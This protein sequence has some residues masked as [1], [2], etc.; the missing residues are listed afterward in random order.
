MF[1]KCGVK[2]WLALIPCVRDVKLGQVAGRENEGRV[3]AVSKALTIAAYLLET[4]CRLF[5]TNEAASDRLNI[6]FNIFELLVGLVTMIYS[7]RVYLGLVEVF[8]RKKIWVLYEGNGQTKTGM[9]SGS[10]W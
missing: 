10:I 7:I 4:A 5:V 9:R 8:D 6:F 3:L 1:K 2:G